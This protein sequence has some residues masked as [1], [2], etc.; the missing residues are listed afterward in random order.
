[1]T[2]GAHARRSW[3]TYREALGDSVAVG[4]IALDDP[5]YDR[6]TWWRFT[7]GIEKVPWEIAGYAYARLFFIWN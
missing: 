1:M 3:L 6:Q 7:E 5:S 4:I 2:L